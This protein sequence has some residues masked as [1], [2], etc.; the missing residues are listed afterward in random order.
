MNFRCN[1]TSEE[2]E[3]ASERKRKRESENEIEQTKET[4]RLAESVSFYMYGIGIH[5][6][7]HDDGYPKYDSSVTK[8]K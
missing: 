3:Q 5:M 2:S 6:Q 7:R 8:I 1:P 4:L